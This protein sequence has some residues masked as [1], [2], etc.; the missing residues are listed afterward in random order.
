M[1]MLGERGVPAVL[2]VGE[3]HKA[4]QMLVELNNFKLVTLN[5]VKVHG[6]RLK[7]GM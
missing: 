2:F 3:D 5:P 7:M 4:G 1:P 6:G